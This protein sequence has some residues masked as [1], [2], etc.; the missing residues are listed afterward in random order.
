[1][2]CTKSRRTKVQRGCYTYSAAVLKIKKHNARDGSKVRAADNSHKTDAAK[3][4][5]FLAQQ[6]TYCSGDIRTACWDVVFAS[7]EENERLKKADLSWWRWCTALIIQNFLWDC[8]CEIYAV[9][10]Q[11]SCL[12]RYTGDVQPLQQVFPLQL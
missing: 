3:L 12:S 2:V 11:R 10:Q 4:Q 7:K 8:K 6:E 5:F 9:C 1:M